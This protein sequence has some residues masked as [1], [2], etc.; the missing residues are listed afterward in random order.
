MKTLLVAIDNSEAGQ[1]I[2]KKSLVIATSLQARVVVVAVT[3]KY[4]GNMNRLFIDDVEGKFN[5]PFQQSLRRAE[6]YAVSLG[7]EIKTI[8]CY[9]KP[10][11]EIARAARE[12]GASLLVLGCSR[13]YHLERM[14]L[15]R[16]TAEIVLGSHCDVMLVPE[17]ADIGFRKLLVG[18][19]GSESAQLAWQ[20]SQ[21]LAASYGGE[22]HALHAIDL[23]VE[24]SLRYGVM[25]EAEGKSR[26]LLQK[27][28]ASS[29]LSEEKLFTIMRLQQPG[30]ALAEYAREKDMN[31]IIL[32]AIGSP[33]IFEMF[34]GSII[35]KTAAMSTCPVLIAKPG[36]NA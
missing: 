34:W 17:K 23:P 26:A 13:K 25:Q 6:E 24:R 4:E 20:R 31:L 22:V 11:E 2:F 29:E 12:I 19:N 32:G 14:L 28:R 9:G 27:L 30:K 1:N 35:E 15:G 18:I 8:H 5:A 3:P 36:L 7:L 10:S 33:S 16:T 21:E